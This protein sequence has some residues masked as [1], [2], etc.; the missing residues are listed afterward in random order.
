MK[1]CLS[2]PKRLAFPLFTF[3]RCM[4]FVSCSSSMFCSFLFISRRFS[5]PGFTKSLSTEL[6]PP[7]SPWAPWATAPPPDTSERKRE[8]KGA[9]LE[10]ANIL[11]LRPVLFNH[12]FPSNASTSMNKD[13]LYQG[14][15]SVCWVN[16]VLAF[17]GKHFERLSPRTPQHLRAPRVQSSAGLTKSCA[18]LKAGK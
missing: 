15:I 2:H 7:R 4:F 14:A 10:T 5:S 17:G 6:K 18:C 3:C 9:I 11:S 1:A 12:V 8:E 16:R 13:D